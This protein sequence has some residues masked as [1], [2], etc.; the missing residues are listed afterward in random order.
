MTF[1]ENAENRGHESI[2]HF[3][4][5]KTGLRAII[6]IHSTALGPA[7]GGARRWQYDNEA[8]ATT[9]AL[10]LARGMTY[11]NAMAGLPLGGGKAVILAD[12]GHTPS[13]EMFLAFGRCVESLG[14]R[15]VT[16]ED[17]GMTMGNMRTIK[18]VTDFVAGLP[19]NEGS[20]GGDPSPWTADGV[21][22][23]LEAA[24]KHRL[25][26]NSLKNLR[27]AVQGVGK[28]GYDLC[29][30]LHEAGAEL[31]ISD[32]NPVHLDRTRADF[33]ARVVAPEQILFEDVDVLSP[34]ALGA[35]LNA[36]S[37]PRIKAKVI[38]GAA[39]NQLATEEDGQ[40]LADRDILYAP[41]YVINAGGII[42]VSLEYMGNKTAADVR[43]QIALIPGRLEE[44]F[45]TA[46]KQQQLT[47]VV[48]DAMAERIVNAGT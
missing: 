17:V 35:I 1:F 12:P 25:G 9:D 6:A 23:G 8:K 5:A 40:R 32:V 42:S 46:E 7:A 4:D 31:T 18:Q 20:A 30:Q 2:H 24:A 13:E 14:G 47:N 21:F 45:I 41:D 34:N 26:A 16:A 33:G 38:G 3:H 36:D 28:V 29:R 22:L 43:E 19:P 39:N 27:I 11:K 10:R 15:Y 37:I 48:A 44:V